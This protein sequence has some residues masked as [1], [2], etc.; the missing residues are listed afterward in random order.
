M[1]ELAPNPIKKL[2]MPTN[3]RLIEVNSIAQPKIAKFQAQNSA[4]FLLLLSARIGMTIN[5]ISDPR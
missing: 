5:P 4:C 1:A 3:G 2:P